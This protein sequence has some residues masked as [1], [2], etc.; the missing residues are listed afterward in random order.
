MKSIYVDVD[1]IQQQKLF[2]TMSGDG[3]VDEITTVNVYFVLD[4]KA[5][6]SNYEDLVSVIKAARLIQDIIGVIERTCQVRAEYSADNLVTT[7][8]FSFRK[9]L[10]NQ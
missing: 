5:L 6:L 10:T 3:T 7:F 8:T 4:A 2:D 9:M 1:Q